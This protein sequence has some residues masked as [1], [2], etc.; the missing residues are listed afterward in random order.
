MGGREVSAERSSLSGLSKKELRCRIL[1][2]RKGLDEEKRLVWD[3]QIRE[4]LLSLTEISAADTV[5]C[6]AD[7]RKEAGT[8]GFI[9]TLLAKGVRVALPRVE[10]REISFCYIEGPWDLK[11][12]CMDIPEPGTACTP[13]E[14]PTAP[15]V[16]PGLAFGRDFSR[17]GYGGGY[18]DRFFAKEPMHRKVAVCY[19]F[20]LTD[21]VLTEKHDVRMDCI[22]TPDRCLMR[23]AGGRKEKGEAKDAD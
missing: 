10:G 4:R 12:G 5:Y 19:E 3:S 6:Y 16:V 13:A 8:G 17:I 11:P 20:Q 7:V 9:E 21:A 15:V 23:E 1:S 18:Y 22:V 2:A 14:E